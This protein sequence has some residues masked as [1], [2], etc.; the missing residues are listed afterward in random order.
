MIHSW[1]PT[2]SGAMGPVGGGVFCVGSGMGAVCVDVEVDVVAGCGGWEGVGA[3]LV[4][5]DVGEVEAADGGVGVGTGVSAPAEGAED[6]GDS[7]VASLEH[8]T[9]RRE[10]RRIAI[11]MR[12]FI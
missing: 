8:D 5:A 9:N 12:V 6:A 10:A 1:V 3:T 4:G 7:W 2:S 11:G